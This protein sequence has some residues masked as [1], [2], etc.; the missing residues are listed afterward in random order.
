MIRATYVDCL[1]LCRPCNDGSTDRVRI[2]GWAAGVVGDG[3]E[4][5]PVHPAGSRWRQVRFIR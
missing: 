5:H 3:S 4:G 2:Y 1:R